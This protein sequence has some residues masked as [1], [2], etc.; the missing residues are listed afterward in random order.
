MFI[1]EYVCRKECKEYEN[2]RGTKQKI[3][4]NPITQKQPLFPS[5]SICFK[6]IESEIGTVI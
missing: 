5:L 1:V 4:F 3:T 6:L 2:T